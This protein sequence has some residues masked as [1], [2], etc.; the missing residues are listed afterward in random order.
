MQLDDNCK[1]YKLIPYTLC[2]IIQDATLYIFVVVI[3]VG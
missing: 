2:W 3:E 1:L